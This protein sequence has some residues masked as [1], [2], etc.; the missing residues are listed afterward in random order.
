MRSQANGLPV[1]VTTTWLPDKDPG[2]VVQV[3]VDYAFQPILQLLPESLF[4]LNITSTSEMVI[5]F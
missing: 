2:S 5:T 3:T 1:T 4:G